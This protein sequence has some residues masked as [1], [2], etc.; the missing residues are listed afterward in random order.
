MTHIFVPPPR[1]LTCEG[2]PE[3]FVRDEMLVF[4]GKSIFAQQV[5]K[6]RGSGT[7]KEM[8]M[9]THEANQPA[10]IEIADS[11]FGQRSFLLTGPD[12]PAIHQENIKKMSEMSTE[13]ILQEQQKLTS[14]L[15]PKLLQFI[16]SR[17]KGKEFCG[18]VDQTVE[19]PTDIPELTSEDSSS[20]KMDTDLLS[21]VSRDVG[22]SPSQYNVDISN[23]SHSE[24][25]I[26][27]SGAAVMT[28]GLDKQAQSNCLENDSTSCQ[29][30]TEMGS[31]AVDLPVKPSEANKWLHMD[32][33]ER[34]KLQWIGNLPPAPS[35]PP[36]TPY[37]ARFDFQGVLLPY[38]DEVN[39]TQALHHHGEEPER[40]GYTLQELLKISRSSVLQQRVLALTTLANI[41][42]KTKAGYYDECMEAP[43]LNQLMDSDLYLL[44]RFS[45]DDSS[46][47]VVTAT[48]LALR[49]LLFNHP[50]ELCLDRLLG[51]W[52]GQYQPT[53]MVKT[54]VTKPSE[55]TEQGD[56]EAELKDHQILRLDIVKGA[57]RTDLIL[58]LRYI[59]ET[60]QPGPKAVISVLEILTRIVRHSYDSALAVTCCPRL[61]SII[62][63]N[64]VRSGWRGI[65]ASCKSSETSSVYGVPQVEALKLLRVIAS[66]S[67]SMASDL[68]HK[69]RVV[70]SI[71][72]YISIV[73]R[74][75]GLP[76]QEAVRLCLES[77]YLWST[78][79]A[80]SLSD[81]HFVDL[82]PVLM[83]VLHFHHSATSTS[84]L[85]SQ[86]G[87][88]HGA[89][90][91]S[92]LKEAMLVADAQGKRSARQKVAKSTQRIE[93]TISYEHLSGFSQI[94][95][96]CLKKWINQLT[97]A[98][99]V[100]FSALKLVAAT[101]NCSAVQYSIFLGQPGLVSVSLL[102]IEDLMNCA[103]LPLLNSSN[104]KLICS[105]VKSSSCL[106]SMKRS[107]KD[108]D[109]Q[110]LPS[111]GALVWGGR[112][113]MPSISPTSPLALLQALAHFLTSVCSVHQGIHLQSIQHFLDNPH[114]LEYIAQL[115]SQKLQ[116]GDSW[117][118]RVET[119]MLADMLK[120]L[121]VVL[122]ATNFQHIGLFHTMAL[123]L[124]SLIPTDEKFLAKEI[125]NH[126]VF[127]PDFISDFSD[128]ACSLEALKLADLSSKQEQSSIHKLL[129]KATLKIPNLWQCYQL[130]L[131][132]DSVTERCPVD[133]SSQTA[134][135]NGCEPAF[136]N[137][138]AYLPILILYNQAH[139]GKGDS[140]DN[141]GSVVSSLQWLLI[142]ECLRPQMMATISVTA[143]FCRLSTV[144]LAG[145]DL[146][147]EPEVHHHLSALLH[148]LLRSNSSFDF[149]EKIP[150]LTSFYDLY[151]QLVEQFAA[152][153][154]GDELFGHFLLIPLQ[155]RH[156]PS[157]RKLVWSEHAAV[158]RVL[159]TRP[160]Q[161]AV[162]IQAYLEPCETDPSLLICYLH[163]LA[164]GQVRDLWCP[165]LYKVAVHHVATF[166]TE[167]PCTSVAQQ[168]NARIQQL[169]NKQLQNILL[170]YSNQK[171]LEDR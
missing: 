42:D 74:E 140:S 13:E 55:K 71:A 119:A 85:G 155:Q 169:G 153:S 21:E 102:E 136:P 168:L 132:L 150:G 170:T 99:E 122:P 161:L 87:H 20:M 56:E 77:I 97:R 105:R 101:L 29:T 34:E 89:A 164:T 81:G 15:D 145:S 88:E 23:I 44:F 52:N 22:M 133:I 121:K 62:I 141:A 75:C 125:F 67:R 128:V 127:N 53:L 137:D 82:Y 165:V 162:P 131:H 167:Q 139:S 38:A 6:V 171:K 123:Q 57:L 51:L 43:V 12:A 80:Y 130:S 49:N 110:S 64:F 72:S 47:A 36:D 8:L 17:R 3:P 7:P 5:E 112:E 19:Q 73:P 138:W 2:F 92:L 144:F 156:S 26:Q 94:L 124:V 95:H 116:A 61:L 135:K 108:R 152:V 103:I 40:P 46:E 93:V 86:F 54:E 148:I 147:L 50:D 158:L 126:A 35:A 27:I 96:L 33:I 98:E 151:T 106:L 69:F 143:R 14:Q 58:R 37:S 45:L 60:L 31:I 11:Q 166:I 157:Y 4:K 109:P 1:A 120:L 107:G 163:G 30:D 149:N 41:L 118:T 142:M 90:V 91:M 134:G 10:D 28:S 48:L 100:T 63:N 154:Y 79:L 115:G 113:V 160:E 129:E 76:E 59:L 84:E 16:R 104:F 39:V 159:R 70:E 83:S 9:D 68:V 24:D 32:V 111:L 25:K 146:F 65:A 117:F 78:L 114:I 18:I 66:C